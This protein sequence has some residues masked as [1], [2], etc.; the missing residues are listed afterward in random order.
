MAQSSFFV[1]QLIQ[2]NVSID[3]YKERTKAKELKPINFA[4]DIQCFIS[5]LKLKRVNINTKV[6][7]VYLD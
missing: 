5:E 2:Q 4:N 3:V 1:K 6:H 7:R